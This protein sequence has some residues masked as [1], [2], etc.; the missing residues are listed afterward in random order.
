MPNDDSPPP[1][2]PPTYGP[3]LPPG[4]DR[5]KVRKH[6]IDQ[7]KK[8]A[9][10]QWSRKTG[11][12]CSLRRLLDRSTFRRSL[13]VSQI[14]SF[15]TMAECRWVI[16]MACTPVTSHDATKI[17]PL[18]VPEQV[19]EQASGTTR[20]QRFPQWGTSSVGGASRMSCHLDIPTTCSQKPQNVY[21]ISSTLAV[22]QRSLGYGR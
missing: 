4:I 12:E 13:G 8:F 15:A 7:L 19:K 14:A 1:P 11:T 22:T 2:P 5:G 21:S 16:A 20:N 3:V 17:R 18:G 6:A 10:Q 9:R